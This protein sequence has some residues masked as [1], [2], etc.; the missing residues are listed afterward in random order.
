MLNSLLRTAAKKA[1]HSVQLNAKTLPERSRELRTSTAEGV[2][3]TS[4][5][6]LSSLVEDLRQLRQRSTCSATPSP[7]VV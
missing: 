4:T 3:A 2:A 1:R 5:Q 7:Y 6:L